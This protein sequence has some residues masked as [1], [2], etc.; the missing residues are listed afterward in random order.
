MCL[1]WDRRTLTFPG[2][3]STST[4]SHTPKKGSLFHPLFPAVSLFCE[5]NS[6]LFE[7]LEIW[8]WRSRWW[9]LTTGGRN[10]LAAQVLEL[11]QSSSAPL[12]LFFP[13]LPSSSLLWPWWMRR[14]I[15]CS[16][17]Y[18]SSGFDYNARW[19]QN[20]KRRRAGVLLH[21]KEKLRNVATFTFIRNIQSYH[22]LISWSLQFGK[23]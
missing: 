7:S 10:V 21:K 17:E 8:K 20:Q 14:Y 2:S 11:E 16:S 19:S 22:W 9:N 18:E 15:S 6:Q 1:G 3:T 5:T 13:P 4:L 23:N 12:T